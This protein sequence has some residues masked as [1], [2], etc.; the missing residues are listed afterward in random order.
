MEKINFVNNSE[1]ALNATNLN[2]LQ[3]NIEEAIENNPGSDT[4][5]INS[6]V[7]YNG[8]TVPTGWQQIHTYSTNEIETGDTWIDD[9]P[10]Y[11]KVF[12]LGKLPNATNKTYDLDGLNTS[13]IFPVELKIIG[14]AN[15]G[16]KHFPQDNV[17]VSLR[18]NGLLIEP[19]TADLSSMTGYTIIEYTKN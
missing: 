5:P 7:D 16:I 10:I 6:I 12:N 17:S 4:L 14:V 3:Q 9:K 19:Q 13:N 15:W 8:E 11:R 1:P 2:K 18:D